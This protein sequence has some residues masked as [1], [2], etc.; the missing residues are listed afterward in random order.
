MGTTFVA[1]GM[2]LYQPFSPF[3]A[4]MAPEVRRQGVTVLLNGAGGDDVMDGEP[5]LFSELAASGHPLNAL[6]RA[7]RLRGP[8][9]GGPAWRVRQYIMRPL[10][11]AATPRGIRRGRY[12]RAL[13]ARYPWAGPRLRRYLDGIA[14]APSRPTLGLA[15]TP[16]ARFEALARSSFLFQS[17][18]GRAQDEALSGCTRRDP[19]FD[20]SFMRTVARLPPLALMH[21]DFRRGLLRE[22]MRGLVPDEVR[23]RETKAFMEPGL[24]QMVNAAGGFRVL[25]GLAEV[26]RL[27]DLGIAEP[28]AFRR[29][30]DALARDPDHG[31]WVMI[32]PALAAEAFLRGAGAS[33]R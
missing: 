26:S 6:T 22:A 16:A 27:A 3:L 18:L 5:N 17:C 10:I 23:L 24:G 33:W 30:L 25:D 8:H 2:P 11:R 12:R 15:A 13:L 28:R 29:A 4:A 1:D 9:M 14:S 21:G 32:W 20:E 31:P 19:F 7:I